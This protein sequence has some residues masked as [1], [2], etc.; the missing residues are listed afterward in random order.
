MEK[1]LHFKNLDFYYKY[2]KSEKNLGNILILHGWWGSSDSRFAIAEKLCTLGYNVYIPDLPWFWKTALN[3]VYTVDDYAKDVEN[4][5]MKLNIWPVILI[6]HSNGGRISIRIIKNKLI[7]VKKLFLIGSAG[8]KPKKTL[9][10]WVFEKIAKM[11]KI[12]QFLPWYSFFRKILYKLIGGHDYLNVGSEFTKQTFLNM[13]NTDQKDEIASIKVETVL[14][15]GDKDTYTPIKDWKVMNKLIS[16][17]KLI[18]LHGER[19]W[20]HLQ[21]PERLFWEISKYV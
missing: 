18:I 4:F 10:K 3:R 11:L 20:I 9:K 15:R 2:F 7:Q 5:E 8:I 16:D 19:H 21:N 1:I 6:G 12:F 17:S 13:I 14:I